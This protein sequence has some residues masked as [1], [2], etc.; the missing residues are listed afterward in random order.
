MMK[1]CIATLCW[2]FL[3]VAARAQDPSY[4]EFLTRFAKYLEFEDTNNIGTLLA[5]SQD[6]AI[7][8]FIGLCW[9]NRRTPQPETQ[10]VLDIMKST[11]REKLDTRTLEEIERYV[12]M[13]SEQVRQDLYQ[14][15]VTERDVWALYDEAK[16]N[17]DREA[18][19]S[20]RQG[21]VNLAKAYDQLGHAINAAKMWGFASEI[22]NA[23]P[24]P[25]VD[26]KR[27]A[28]EYVG[29]FLSRREQWEWTTDIYY[30]KNKVWHESQLK[31]L[32]ASEA[33]A[34]K[35]KDEGYGDDVRGADAFVMPGAEEQIVDLQFAVIKKPHV[36]PFVQG[37]TVPALWLPVRI[38]EDTPQ[39]FAVF[40]GADL[41]LVRPGSSKFGV[42]L[43]GVKEPFEPIEPSGK[44]K[45]SLFHL[46]PDKSK[47]YA[48][49]FYTG[50]EQEPLFGMTH[51][52]L[53]QE[54]AATIYYK[55]ASSWEAT[56]NGEAVTFFDDN[57][58]GVLFE[59]D[60]YAYGL[61]DRTRE[62]ED[63]D[64]KQVPAFD[65]MQ[66]GNGSVQPLSQFVKI[67][68]GW[69]HL[70]SKEDGAK[71]GVRPLN[72]EYVK[73]GTVQL[74]WKGPR[75]AKPEMLI[76]QG[77]GDFAAARYNIAADKSVEV[78]VGEY[79]IAFGRITMGKGNRAIQAQ[80]YQGGMAPI[81][82]KAGET[83]DVALGAP[84]KLDFVRGGNGD[85]VEIDAMKISVV[86]D[87]G[88]LYCRING[89]TPTP[90]VMVSK[91]KNVKSGK[92][93]GE[94]TL[95]DVEVMNKA[96][97]KH[98]KL[99]IEMGFFA[100]P[101]GQRDGDV[102]FKAKVPITKGFVGLREKKNKL[103]G[104]LDPIFK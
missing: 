62:G 5:K 84:F 66:I 19:H 64:G 13:Q 7:R 81:V 76:L 12:V 68:D 34:A 95:M 74:K 65:G 39:K 4:N 38:A 22:T 20:A 40:K 98:S 42:S 55:S 50:G 53:P 54:D 25:T 78:P 72:P 73:T 88:E 11:W 89:A 24:Q 58:N 69:V 100:A 94:F 21:A 92:V 10:K 41:Y 29:N 33:A 102:V 86:G 59:E 83:T 9:N 31:L 3:A 45:A 32:E 61:R 70:R 27:E 46:G 87:Q 80:I 35:R 48:L 60:P 57:A 77:R 90:E 101:K 71:V 8:H 2:L 104:K 99:G 16:K 97:E 23:L 82:V 56:I 28:V 1:P 96:V 85:E 36:D 37:G 103:F 67:G 44:F 63:S 52:L 91:K 14:T 79:E 49:W 30:K 6:Q 26:E 18:Y 15:E 93:I 43:N 75:P 51:N 47:P 17:K